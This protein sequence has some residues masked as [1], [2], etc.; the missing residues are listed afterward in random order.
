MRAM[1]ETDCSGLLVLILPD[2]IAA[3]PN[4]LESGNTTEYRTN[5]V[6]FLVNRLPK[7]NILTEKLVNWRF[8]R[9]RSDMESAAFTYHKMTKK[10]P[11]V[12]QLAKAPL[13]YRGVGGSNPAS[14]YGFSCLL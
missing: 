9:S 4:T 8:R 7:Y 13:C 14:S 10:E 1:L 5:L 11:L 2:P 12:A 3:Q 6:S